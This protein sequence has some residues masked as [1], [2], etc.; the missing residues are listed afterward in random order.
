MGSTQLKYTRLRGLLRG[1]GTE[2]AWGLGHGAENMRGRDGE[3]ETGE[4]R[5]ETEKGNF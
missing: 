5:P 2:M 3:K 1:L 4:W